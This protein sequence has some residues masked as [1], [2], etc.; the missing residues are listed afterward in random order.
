[1]S[2]VSV[3]CSVCSFALEWSPESTDL[4]LLARSK[5][6]IFT[7]WREIARQFWIAT[8]FIMPPARFAC[9]RG[10]QGTVFCIGAFSQFYLRMFVDQRRRV[11]A[12]LVAQ[13]L[14]KRRHTHGRRSLQSTCDFVGCEW[15]LFWGSPQGHFC[16]QMKGSFWE[17]K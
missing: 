17:P 13:I 9:Y 3:L 2:C 15:H 10:S 14:G 12:Q 7:P 1:M 4:G 16:A 5:Y 8:V 6:F 11:S